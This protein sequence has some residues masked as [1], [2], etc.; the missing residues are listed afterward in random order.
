MG[1]YGQQRRKPQP[2]SIAPCVSTPARIVRQAKT[3]LQQDTQRRFA[4]GYSGGA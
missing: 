2:R 3:A 4:F 1:Y